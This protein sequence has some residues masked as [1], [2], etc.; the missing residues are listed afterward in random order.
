MS[1]Y[2]IAVAELNEN[3]RKN[4]FKEGLISLNKITSNDPNAA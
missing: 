4:N 1:K 3:V 2:C